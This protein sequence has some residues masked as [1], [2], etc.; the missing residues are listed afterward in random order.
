M[1]TDKESY[2]LTIFFEGGMLCNSR[3]S[4][5]GYIHIQLSNLQGR[6]WI[7]TSGA[8]VWKVQMSGITYVPKASYVYMPICPYVHTQW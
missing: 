7:Y 5:L 3:E 6:Y 2:L 8:G 4:T 1:G